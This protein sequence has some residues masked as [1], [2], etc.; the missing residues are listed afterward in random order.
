MA[1]V[2]LVFPE[3][4]EGC[5][6]HI[7]GR[8]LDVFM[9]PL[10]ARRPRH[11]RPDAEA[12]VS[13]LEDAVLDRAEEALLRDRDEDDQR[14]AL[15]AFRSSPAGVRAG[16]AA[17]AAEG[18]AADYRMVTKYLDLVDLDRTRPPGLDAVVAAVRPTVVSEHLV[19]SVLHAFRLRVDET[20]PHDPA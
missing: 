4:D 5:R 9:A 18:R 11:E 16:L 20:S 7:V 15:L 10:H 3:V 13:A 8:T 14:V 12:L 2:A 17:L 1:Y 6:D 19:R